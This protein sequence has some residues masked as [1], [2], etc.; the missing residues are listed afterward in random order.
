MTRQRF[1]VLVILT[2]CAAAGLHG[3]A[4]GELGVPGGGRAGLVVIVA[5]AFLG[6]LVALGGLLA[7]R[8]VVAAVVLS[9]SMAAALI[10]GLTFHYLLHTPDHVAYAPPGLWGDVFRSSA[11]V[12]AV[13]EALGV[14]AGVG[15]M[16]F[17]VR[18]R[19]GGHVARRV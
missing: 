9:L 6:P 5:A 16:P 4:H 2:H 8:R 15:L 10:Y 1:A 11:A 7:G 14:V 13:L 3:A 12:I 19:E 17:R 18:H